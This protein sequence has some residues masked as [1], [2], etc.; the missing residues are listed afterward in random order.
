[1]DRFRNRVESFAAVLGSRQCTYQ[2]LTLPAGPASLHHH[3]QSMSLYGQSWFTSQLPPFM[4]MVTSIVCSEIWTYSLT[5]P[6]RTAVK[7][8]EKV[9]S[10]PCTLSLGLQKS[11]LILAKPCF[12][13]KLHNS[14]QT[15]VQTFVNLILLMKKCYI[16]LSPLYSMCTP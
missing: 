12:G 8:G 13:K 6:L 1:M 9:Y 14:Y 10:S 5:Q 2:H 4:F 11:V 16:E 3:A 15:N 7:V